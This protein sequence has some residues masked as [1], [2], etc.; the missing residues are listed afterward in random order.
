VPRAPLTACLVLLT[1]LPA[2]GGSRTRSSLRP[3]D[4]R[5]EYR[6]D[7]AGLDVRQPRLGWVLEAAEGVDPLRVRGQ[8]QTA[9][10]ISRRR[11]WSGC[12]IKWQSMSSVNG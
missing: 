2:C 3:T 12:R 8:R 7:P 6:V 1:L 9:Y 4:L 5:C 11:S 10:H